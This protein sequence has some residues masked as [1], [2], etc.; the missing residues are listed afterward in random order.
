MKEGEGGKGRKA[1]ERTE[2]KR[3]LGHQMTS[4]QSPKHGS[5][6]WEG[7]GGGSAMQE[8][9]LHWSQKAEPELEEREWK[10]NL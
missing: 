2:D 4:Q 9:E 8:A 5:A 1:G 6:Q 10:K 3:M 7:V